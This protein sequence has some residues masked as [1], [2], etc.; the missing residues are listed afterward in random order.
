MN[1][2]THTDAAALSMTTTAEF[3]ASAERAWQLVSDPRQLE[4]WWGPPEWPATFVRFEFEPE[5]RAHYYMQGPDGERLHGWWRFVSI[6]APTELLIEDGFADDQGEPSADLGVTTARLTFEPTA[7]G[8]R[9]TIFS[10]FESL[11]QLEE[12][13]EM[14]M[15]EGMR[16]AVGQIAAIL[17]DDEETGS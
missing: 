13:I 15:E 7:D 8:T 2:S 12:M 9:L 3:T 1:I 10:Q 6:S 17:G 16:L 5:G 11:E 14:G 4:R